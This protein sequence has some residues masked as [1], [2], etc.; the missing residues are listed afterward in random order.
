MTF[1]PGSVSAFQVANQLKSQGVNIFTL[2]IQPTA[3]SNQ[4]TGLASRVPYNFPVPNYEAL[5]LFASTVAQVI[6]E[7]QT[8]ITAFPVLCASHK[9][10]YT[11]SCRLLAS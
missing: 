2:G 7:G 8:A 3:D 9:Q 11:M 1:S 6:C 5:V 4:L 10:T